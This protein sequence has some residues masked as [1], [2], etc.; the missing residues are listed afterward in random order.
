M[1]TTVFR[2]K[3]RQVRRRVVGCIVL[4]LVSY[5]LFTILT[6]ILLHVEVSIVDRF[7]LTLVFIIAFVILPFVLSVVSHFQA[8][9]PIIPPNTD[10]DIIDA[11]TSGV[12][13]LGC[14]RLRKMSGQSCYG[15]FGPI[16]R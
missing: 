1:V 16:N 14:R 11:V 8:D 9:Q 3:A 13:T 4:I 6:I 5:L 2:I 12:S 10:F 15:L 7:K